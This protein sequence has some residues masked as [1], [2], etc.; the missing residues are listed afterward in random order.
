MTPE[1]R[2]AQ[3]ERMIRNWL[4]WGNPRKT[5]DMDS[6]ITGIERLFALPL[7]EKP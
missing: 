7:E 5:V 2:R 1:D 6:L 4:T 3:L